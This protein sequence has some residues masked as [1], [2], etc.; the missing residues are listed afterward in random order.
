[1]DHSREDILALLHGRRLDRLPVFGVLPSLTA[2]GIASTGARYAELHTDGA[3]MADAAA[4]TF[5]IYGWSRGRS[6]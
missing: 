4:S 6:V 2:K 1:M 3:K 5:E